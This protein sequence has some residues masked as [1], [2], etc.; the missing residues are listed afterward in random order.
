MSYIYAGSIICA[1]ITAFVLMRHETSFQQYANRIYVINLLATSYCALLFILVNTGDIISVPHFFKTAAAFSFVMPPLAYLYLKAV[2][3]D[4]SKIEVRDLIHFIP[5]LLI[6]ISYIPFYFNSAA[7]KVY[8][9]REAA[10]S[11]EVQVGLLSEGTYFN[12]R[13]LQLAFYVFL[14]WRLLFR[15]QDN[16]I[17]SALKSFTKQVISWLK[18]IAILHTL[19]FVCFASIVIIVALAG[20][21]SA[22]S[23]VFNLSLLIFGL[24]ILI[25]NSYL[26]LNPLV[27]YGLDSRYKKKQPAQI[28]EQAKDLK[29]EL[30]L[31]EHEQKRLFDYFLEKKPYLKKGLSIAEVSVAIGVSQR[32]ISFILNSQLGVRFSDFVNDYRIQE[33]AKQIDDGYLGKFTIASLAGKVG[34]TS[35][36][37]FG[38]AFK[39]IIELTPLEYASRQIESEQKQ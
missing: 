30:G 39:K 38:R 20:N 14:M 26:L 19:Q 13:V 16:T 1:L 32:S 37:T 7:Y 11:T 27:L 36:K 24:T 3:R 22:V 18:A 31:F 5:F 21:I 34:F 29:I 4:Q 17:P 12:L 8:M 28:L 23:G 9:I 25:L 15:F 33:A 2:L 6:L 10:I 35:V